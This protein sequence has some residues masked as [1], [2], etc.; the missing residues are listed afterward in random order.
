MNPNWDYLT[1]THSLLSEQS[2]QVEDG[3]RAH[4]QPFNQSAVRAWLSYCGGII[5]DAPSN[6]AT[7]KAQYG[8]YE[9]ST[10]WVSEMHPISPAKQAGRRIYRTV[11]DDGTWVSIAES[12]NDDCS[13]RETETI[14]RRPGEQAIFWVFD[15]LGQRVDHAYFPTRRMNEDAIRFAPD[16]CM[17]C[18]YTMDTRRFDVATPSFEALNLKLF[19]TSTGPVWRDHSHC[20][21]PRDTLIYHQ[22]PVAGQ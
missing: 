21:H 8:D 4:I 11:L 15:G 7:F 19:E 10:N 14:V 18:H 20:A 3:T 13:V 9:H 5:S 6:L 2:A 1:N 22:V 17:G 16:S 12:T